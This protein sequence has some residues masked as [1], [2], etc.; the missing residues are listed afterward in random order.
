MARRVLLALL[1]GCV[2]AGCGG[3]GA[4]ARHSRK[5][6]L[7]W[8][9]TYGRWSA[10]LRS[11]VGAAESVRASLLVNDSRAGEFAVAV[12]RL[13]TCADRYRQHVADPPKAGWRGPA[14]LALEACR[15]LTRGER[16][17]LGAVGHEAGDLRFSGQAALDKA[18]QQLYLANS[19]FERSFVWNRPLPR[20]GGASRRSRI[21]PLF[22][23]V[24]TP[25]ARR[26]VEIR[27]WSADDWEIVLADT[28]H[29]L[30]ARPILRDSS[31]APS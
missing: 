18:G 8:L 29:S 21:E 20:I 17:F 27:C 3:N 2:L 15:R 19:Q 22:S 14:R 9:R 7:A 26:P 13:A 28:A 30:R 4:P 12:T 10:R 11:D 5:A 16:H 6:D 23:R 1:A 31:T 24:A 25:I